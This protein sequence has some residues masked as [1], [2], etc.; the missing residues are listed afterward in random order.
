MHGANP[1]V[2]TRFAGLE[3]QDMQNLQP[4]TLLDRRRFIGAGAL[5]LAGV[6]RLALAQ[7]A[8]RGAGEAKRLSEI[9]AEFV[10]GFDLKDVSP[11][12]IERTRL[13]FIDT[14]G[15]MLAGSRTHVAGIAYDM[16][17]AE[18]SAP[19]A[20]IVGQSSRAS[21]QLAA[22]AN[23]VAGHA[24]DY[25]FTF[26][27]GQMVAPLI[28]ALLP[29]AESTGATRAQTMAA[30]VVGFEV[31]ARFARAN[32]NIASTAGWHAT[33]AIGTIAAA[34]ASARLLKTPAAA[35]PDVIGISVSMASGVGANYGT[36]TKPLHS[37]LAARNG[38][39]A[40][41][42]GG[43]GFTANP[44][45]IEGRDGFFGA[46]L[47]GLDWKSDPFHDLG[48]RF[49]LVERGFRPKLYPC[50]GLSH[51]AIEATLELRDMLG[52]RLADIT[53]IKAG[54]TKYAS[55]RISD[56]YPASSENA[57]FSMPYI[58][59]YTLV[60]G[61]PMLA[62]F[63]EEAI[64]DEKVRALS[65]K[66]SLVVD[67]A[68]EEYYMGADS[69]TRVTVSL[70]N[71]QTVERLRFHASGSAQMPLT[72]AQVEDKF[73]SCATQAVDKAVATKLFAALNAL[74]EQPTF[75]EFWPLIRRVA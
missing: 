63:T 70:A 49:E 30:F 5:A 66:I 53:G 3:G 23:G 27:I 75:D 33:S 21:P 31:A 64:R 20:S 37:G 73:M 28:P 13:A 47:R 68:F 54:V 41:L 34:A 4:M 50:G 14:M 57:K 58:G 24:L 25:D 59:A 46:F 2:P 48:R 16:V 60:H 42:L 29:L 22:L 7:E 1:A 65:R 40:A 15:V 45:A 32:G 43:R 18:G 74:G 36:M 38:V 56:R 12:A 67:P 19:A 10:V 71:G 52:G 72:K 26:M 44:A 39:M 35:I 17:K 61:A 51:T 69:P 55:K 9:I 62:A 6:P 8:S 11:L